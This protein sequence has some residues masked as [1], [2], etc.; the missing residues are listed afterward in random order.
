MAVLAGDVLV[1][2]ERVVRPATTVVSDATL[3]LAK[4]ARYVSRGG[5]KLEHALRRVRHR[6]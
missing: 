2:G 4:Q 5:E 6:T 3:E 1:N